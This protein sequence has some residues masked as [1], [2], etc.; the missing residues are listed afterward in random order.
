MVG[1]IIGLVVGAFVIGSIGFL[2]LNASKKESDAYDKAM[3]NRIQQ[4]Q[5]EL[6]EEQLDE[7]KKEVIVEKSK[8]VKKEKEAEEVQELTLKK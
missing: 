3:D 6:Q 1:L 5:Q 7:I 4:V 2:I 8:K